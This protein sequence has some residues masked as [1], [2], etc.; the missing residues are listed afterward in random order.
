[1][2]FESR[3]DIDQTKSC[4]A[5]LNRQIVDAIQYW[6]EVEIEFEVSSKIQNK[7]EELQEDEVDPPVWDTMLLWFELIKREVD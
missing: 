6:L 1:M 5:C 4:K 3:K 2:P 7:I